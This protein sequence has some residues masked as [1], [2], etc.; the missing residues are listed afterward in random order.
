M[1]YTVAFA[2]GLILIGISVFK[3]RESL[4]FLKY[5]DRAEGVITQIK[6]IEDSDGDS[7][8][9]YFTFT[10]ADGQEVI[11]KHNF[12][13]DYTTWRIGDKGIIAYSPYN[14]EIAKLVSYWG[15]FSWS[16]VL[17]AAAMPLIVVSVGYYLA[18]TVLK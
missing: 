14:P 18:Q 1:A 12:S 5:S 2:I 6:K 16:I 8:K 10:T 17:M 15:I 9:P 4:K 11:Y 7:Y 3:C 13:S